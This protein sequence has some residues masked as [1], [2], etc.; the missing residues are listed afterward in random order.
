[1]PVKLLAMAANFGVRWL[2]SALER[3]DKSPH[4]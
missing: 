4:S 3:G 1:M 2:V